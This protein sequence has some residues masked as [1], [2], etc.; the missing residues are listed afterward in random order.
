MKF[1]YY[2]FDNLPNVGVADIN[3]T[4][5]SIADIEVGSTSDGDLPNLPI[6]NG[7][8][9]KLQQEDVF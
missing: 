4:L 1:G 2:S 7:I 3:S 6:D 8:L 9:Q 5:Y